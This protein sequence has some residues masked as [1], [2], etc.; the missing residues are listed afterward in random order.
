GRSAGWTRTMRRRLLAA[1]PVLLTLVLFGMW[2]LLNQTLAPAHVALGA[3]LA[4]LISWGSTAFRPLSPK[5]LQP[6]AAVRLV[7]L[8]L[9]DIVWSNVAVARIVLGLVNRPVRS[10]FLEIRLIL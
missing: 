7:L 10:C 2:L 3:V 8:V 1:P 5:V 6:W 9:T 4:L